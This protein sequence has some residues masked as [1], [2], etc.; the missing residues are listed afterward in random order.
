MIFP[1][2]T[3]RRRARASNHAHGP[4]TVTLTA[5]GCCAQ[6]MHRDF[7]DRLDNDFPLPVDDPSYFAIVTGAD[8]APLLVIPG[9]HSLVARIEHL[10]TRGS[11]KARAAIEADGIGNMSIKKT[12]SI[13]PFSVF[14]GRG[15]L[16][17][18]GAGRSQ[19]RRALLRGSIHM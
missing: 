13:K 3:G 14:I 5:P 7:D 15:D 12:V 1:N 19:R 9:S 4:R 11:S 8:A 18:A 16:V 6:C 2:L 10:L 17:H